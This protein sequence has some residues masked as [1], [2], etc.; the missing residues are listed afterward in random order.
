[1]RYVAVEQPEYTE[2]Y[3]AAG[4]LPVR[5]FTVSGVDVETSSATFSVSEHDAEGHRLRDYELQAFVAG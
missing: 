5:I 4:G 1:M 2:V 3:E